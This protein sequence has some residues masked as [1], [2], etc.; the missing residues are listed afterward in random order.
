M[1][2]LFALVLTLILAL[3]LAACGGSNSGDN[4]T[5]TPPA[6]QGETTPPSNG[7]GTLNR[8]EWPDNAYTASVPKPTDLTIAD[9]QQN[10]NLNGDYGGYGKVEGFVQIAITDWTFEAA[11]AYVEALKTAGF[12]GKESVL[13]PSISFKRTASQIQAGETLNGY[14]VGFHWDGDTNKGSI[15]IYKP[16]A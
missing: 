15:T 2:K 9:V 5:T 3:S 16:I 8:T 7:G 14:A 4:A 1:K 6:S 13:E 11:V 10:L 12:P